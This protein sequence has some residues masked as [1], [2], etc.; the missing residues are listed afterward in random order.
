MKLGGEQ[1][2]WSYQPVG[3]SVCEFYVSNSCNK[4]GIGNKIII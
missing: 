4:A 2:Y 3:R 1:V